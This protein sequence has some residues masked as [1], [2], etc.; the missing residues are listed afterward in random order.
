VFHNLFIY[1]VLHCV[2]EYRY[3]LH[4]RQ[5]KLV[6]AI[7]HCLDYIYCD[8]SERLKDGQD[9]L[10]LMPMSSSGKTV[11]V[12]TSFCMFFLCAYEFQ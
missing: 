1:I 6:E 3:I 5:K 9:L 12:K 10:L 4:P 8:A 11:L 7:E 2:L